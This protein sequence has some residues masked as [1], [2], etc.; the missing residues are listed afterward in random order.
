[1]VNEPGTGSDATIYDVARVAGVSPSTVSRAFSRPGRVSAQTAEKIRQVAEELGY[2]SREVSRTAAKSTTKVLGLAVADITNPFNFRVIRG[3]QAAAAEAGFVVTLNDAQESEALEREMLRRSLPLLDG[4]IVASSRLSDTELR[5]VAKQLPVVILNR[6]VAGLHCIIPDMAHGV[7]KATEHLLALGHRNI[8]Y[9]AGPEASW[10]DGMRWRAMRDSAKELGF[11]EHRVGPFAPT[12]QG[13]R[14]AAEVIA[15]RRL[16]AVVCFNDLMAIGL[17]QGLAE[18]GIKV[19][20]QISIIGFDNIFASALVTPGLTTV[21][22]P[23]TMLGD[24]AVRY[25]VSSLAGHKSAETAP[26]SVPVRLIV[27]HS[28][29]PA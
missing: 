10:A 28:T 4:L 15:A 1:M 8:T 22:A 19:P 23:L 25:V 9:L 7:R 5:T 14:G 17:M 2:R 3:C 11:T 6:R 26:V 16:K 12:L 24:S 20:E 13:G 18:R 27:R 21:A 29:G